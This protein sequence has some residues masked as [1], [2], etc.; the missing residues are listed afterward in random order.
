[1]LG[2]SSLTVCGSMRSALSPNCAPNTA[3]TRSVVAGSLVITGKLASVS[4]SGSRGEPEAA[5]SART[6][7]R[8][9]SSIRCRTGSA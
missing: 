1:M 7:C 9:A 8:T 4:K 3:A 5:H 6:I 2:K